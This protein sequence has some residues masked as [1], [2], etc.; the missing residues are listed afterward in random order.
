M[1]DRGE[2]AFLGSGSYRWHA[3]A[4]LIDVDYA[5]LTDAQLDDAILAGRL[6]ERVVDVSEETVLARRR[7]GHQRLHELTLRNYAGCCAVCDIGDRQLL[8]AS[9]VVRWADDFDARGRLDNCLCLCQPHDALFEYG[10]WGMHDDGSLIVR[11]PIPWRGIRVLLAGPPRF[12]MPQSHP[13]APLFLQQHR[14]R[15]A[16]GAR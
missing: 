2:V 1:R 5:D 14:Y 16:L 13:P 12:R 4:P 7:R 11:D 3:M 8:V 15:H 6:R 10:Y 9:H